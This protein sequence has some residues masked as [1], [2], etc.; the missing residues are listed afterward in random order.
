MQV[1]VELLKE[2]K[3]CKEE[4]KLFERLYQ[5]GVELTNEN[6]QLAAKAGLDC[7]WFLRMVKPKGN[8][9]FIDNCETEYHFLDGKK[10]NEN[11]PAVIW[12]NGHVEYFINGKV[13]N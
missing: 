2:H 5:D 8:F 1:T 12:A 10:H 11:G 9:C 13:H 3:A 7:G 6:L 4:I